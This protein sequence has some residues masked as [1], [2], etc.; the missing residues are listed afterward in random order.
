MYKGILHRALTYQGRIKNPEPGIKA[1]QIEYFFRTAGHERDKIFSR[2]LGTIQRLAGMFNAIMKITAGDLRDHGKK[3]GSIFADTFNRCQILWISLKHRRKTAESLYEIMCKRV[4][5]PA[6]NS[7]K[8]EQFEHLMVLKAVQA[9]LEKT[10][11][12]PFAMT[13]VQLSP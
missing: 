8:K 13:C 1:D 5:I 10:H 2:R 4:C 11:T 12:K 7:L 6:G 3:G 9:F